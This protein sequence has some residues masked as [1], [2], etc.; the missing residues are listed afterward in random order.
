MGTIAGV[1][2]DNAQT[3]PNE[4][5]HDHFK[6]PVVHQQSLEALRFDGPSS[7]VHT[8][9]R[10][11]GQSIDFY[12]QLA[13]SEELFV[14]L[15]GAAAKGNARYPMFRR[16]ESLKDRVPSMLSF[17]DPTLTFSDAEDFTIGWYTGGPDWDPLDDIASTVRSA[18]AHTGAQHVM[19]L[20]G[21]AGGH[22]AL[23]ISTR[24]PGSIAL[25][26]DPQT[27]I[28]SYYAP[29]RERLLHHCW[30]G[31]AGTEVLASHSDRFNMCHFYALANPAN[32]I[33]YRQSTGD[34]WHERVHARP[35]QESIS[36]T[37][38]T[39]EGRYRFVYERGEREGHGKINAAEFDR[40]FDRALDF[41]RDKR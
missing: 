17:A 19:F 4:S 10:G 23:R 36:G 40:H 1:T 2:T 39:S 14:S 21:S 18:Q 15:H 8:V 20:G 24:F 33:Y 26:T 38:G 41:W 9:P 6:V 22:A 28:G 30:P 11:P 25:V 3:G 27:D 29:H 7:A 12:A 5:W 13:P 32:F 37:N 34:S 35:F 16:V 31:Q